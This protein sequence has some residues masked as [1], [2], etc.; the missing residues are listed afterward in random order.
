[1]AD[2]T[3]KASIKRVLSEPITFTLSVTADRVSEKGT[4]SG[5]TI[6]AVEASNKGAAELSVVEY[7]SALYI[8][9]GKITEKL[10][11][12]LVGTTKKPAVKLF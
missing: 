1:M 2:T 9:C 3:K 12:E 5:F 8:K 4:F 7:Q 11:G 10:L 6:K